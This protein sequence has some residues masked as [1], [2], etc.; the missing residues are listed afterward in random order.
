MRGGSDDAHGSSALTAS[1]STLELLA[2]AGDHPIMRSFPHG[3]IFTF[4]HDLRYLSAGGF[5]LVDLGIAQEEMTGR[6][7]AE[8]FA[9]TA[10][11]VEPLYRSV[12]RGETCVTDVDFRGR[13]Y[14]MRLAPVLDAAGEVVAGMGITHDVTEAR[15]GERALR[16]SEERFRLTFEN[17]PIGMALVELDGRWRQVNPAALQLLGYSAE[18][19]RATT[20]QQITHP[21]DLDADLDLMR[22][23]VAG[24][25]PSYAMEKR[26][27]TAAGTTVAT[28][29]SVSLVR[30]ADGSPQY[31]VSQIQDITEW[32]TQQAA[33]RDLVNML[34]HDLR[35]PM[36]VV[37][38]Y[39]EMSLESWDHLQDDQKRD[40]L[41]KIAAAA[42]SVQVLLEHTLTVSALDA[43]GLTAQPVAVRVDELVLEVVDEVLTGDRDVAGRLGAA[44]AVVD[45]GHLRQVVSNLASNAVKY[46][47]GVT[48]LSVGEEGEM[49]VV[50][51]GD[52]GPGVPAEFEA[53]LFDRFSRSDQARAGHQRGT[54]LGLHIVRNLLTLNGGDI[55]HS[56]TP[57]GGATFTIRLPRA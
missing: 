21:D 2:R 16:E 44:T 26:Y 11:E 20:F 30:N 14:S 15:M 9:A 19:L 24:S 3:G 7:L 5:A 55:E 1:P 22:H 45:R 56:V 23:L 36:S 13:V 42:H 35:T 17:A 33:L 28:L 51:I 48:S 39:A 57:G 32:K 43:R 25:V 12:L 47:G 34:S 46:G 52:S 27:I 31:F 54:G 10:P 38:G 29:L 41:A 50:S 53:H 4:D 6:T 37:T 49:V 40:F 18:E 8:A